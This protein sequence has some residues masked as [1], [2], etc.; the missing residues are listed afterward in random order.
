MVALEP[1]I[2]NQQD[3]HKGVRYYDVVSVMGQNRSA[4]ALFQ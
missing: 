4:I 2:L 1:L 3:S